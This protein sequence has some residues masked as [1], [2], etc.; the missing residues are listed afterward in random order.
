MIISEK[1]NSFWKICHI[2][3]IAKTG[4]GTEYSRLSELLQA[5]NTEQF[6]FPKSFRMDSN[7]YSGIR[8]FNTRHAN[9]ECQSEV[10]SVPGD[11]HGEVGTRKH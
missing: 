5:F 1:Y 10:S 8:V 11:L 3:T 9:T 4:F 7:Y 6:T 2:L